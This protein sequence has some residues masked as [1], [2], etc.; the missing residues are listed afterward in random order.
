MVTGMMAREDSV[1][2]GY[3]PT[4]TTNDFAYSLRIPKNLLDAADIAVKGFRLPVMWGD[5]MTVFL[6]M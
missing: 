5:S 1:P 3:I 4:G 6:Y 2:I